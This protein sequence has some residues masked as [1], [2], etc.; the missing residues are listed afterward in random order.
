MT[1]LPSD[2]A[3]IA[4]GVAG[5]RRLPLVAAPPAEDRGGGEGADQQPGQRDDE[6]LGHRE[7]PQPSVGL[8]RD[9]PVDERRRSADQE[10]DHDGNEPEG[11]KVGVSPVRARRETDQAEKKAPGNEAVGP[12]AAVAG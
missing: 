2:P 3:G 11:G 10:P 7:D 5:R 1:F 8:A 6:P 9:E 12:A 4:A